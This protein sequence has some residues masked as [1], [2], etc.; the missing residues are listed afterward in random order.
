MGILKP[1]L[2]LLERNPNRLISYQYFE[3]H[4]KEHSTLIYLQVYQEGRK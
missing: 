2:H 3:S 4:R 1:E